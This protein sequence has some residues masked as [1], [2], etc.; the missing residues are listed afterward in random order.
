MSQNL[1]RAGLP[2][3]ILSGKQKRQAIF[4]TSLQPP[5]NSMDSSIIFQSHH[6]QP[7]VAQPFK[8]KQ[9]MHRQ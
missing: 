8:F 9:Y 5:R 3:E 1:K 6:A 4:D 2:E 7:H